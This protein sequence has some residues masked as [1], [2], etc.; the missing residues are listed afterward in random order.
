[1]QV[2][3]SEINTVSPNKESSKQ[4]EFNFQVTERLVCLSGSKFK[5]LSST[6][7]MVEIVHGYLEWVEEVGEEEVLEDP[8]LCKI[9]EIM[10]M[11]NVHVGQFILERKAIEESNS[12]SKTITGKH[13]LLTYSQLN[14][15]RTLMENVSNRFPQFRDKAFLV[16]KKLT[17]TMNSLKKRFRDFIGLRIRESID[18]I[19]VD[20]T[21]PIGGP[22][23]ESQKVVEVL[24]RSCELIR[25][26]LMEEREVSEFIKVEWCRDYLTKVKDEYKKVYKFIM[27][28][29]GTRK[30][31]DVDWSDNLYWKL[32]ELNYMKQS[33]E[34]IGH[35]IPHFDEIVRAAEE[36]K[37]KLDKPY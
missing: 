30:N 15:I 24:L 19:V 18:L 12:K 37:K 27:N 31:R 21:R 32:K 23:K 20:K 5:M 34:G 8:I 1:M 6:L 7:V 2:S 4:I 35:C 14:F 17:E 3:E 13:L 36:E 29:N 22:L 26:N 11:Y 28:S 9:M 10:M 25:D 16:N 33:L